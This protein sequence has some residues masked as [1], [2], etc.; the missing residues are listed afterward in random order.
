MNL[1]P[2][3][4]VLQCLRTLAGPPDPTHLSD[5]HLLLRY[6]RHRDELSFAALVRR[7]APMV[8]GVCCRILTCPQDAEDV[9][10]ATFLVLA[11]K[12]PSLRWRDSVASW[13]FE[14]AH[15]LALK[16]RTEIARRQRH[17]RQAAKMMRMENT[18]DGSLQE[19]S[20][21]LDEELRNLP[22]RY[23]LP[24]LLCY[25]EGRTR[26]Q[27][28]RY[29]GW[30]LRTLHR[31]LER[32][33]ALLRARLTARDLTLSSVLVSAELAQQTVSAHLSATLLRDTVHASLAFSLPASAVRLPAVVLAEQGLRSMA[34]AKGTMMLTLLLAVGVIATGVGVL[35]QRQVEAMRADENIT[36]RT[37]EPL[38]SQPGKSATETSDEPRADASA[39]PAGA[40]ARL[41]TSWLRGGRWW[42]FL[43]DGKR[44]VQQRSDDEALI[45]SAVPS[46]KPLALIRGSDVPGRKEVIG[47]TMAF[48]CDVKYLAAVC[49]EGRCGIWETATG[50]LVRWLE[51]GPFYSIVTCDFSPDGKLLAVGAGTPQGKI[52]GI[53]VGVYEVA[54]GKQLFTT[55]GT[56]SVFAPDGRSL[57]TWDGYGHGALKTARRVEVP[58]GKELTSFAYREHFPDFAPRSDGVWFFEIQ[59]NNSIRVWDV[60]SAKLKHTFPG[61]GGGDARLVYVRHIAGRRE[62]I[63]VSTQPAEVTCWDLRIGKQLWQHR[64]AAPAYYPSLSADGNTLVTGESTGAVRVWDVATGNER[65]SFRPGVIGHTTYEVQVSLDGKR[66]ATH[67]GGSFSSAVAF[68]DAT[69]G[70][71]LSDLPGHSAGITTVAYA[72]NG[73]R[74]FT[75][76]KDRTLRTWDAGSGRELSRI[77]TEPATSLAVSPDSKTLYAGG[78]ESGSVRVLDAQTGR[79]VRQLPVFRKTTIGL[80]LTADG[81]R[82]IAGGADDKASANL[83]V[84]IC[85][86]GTGAKQQ[87]LDRF[88]FSLEQLAI[89][90]DG[91]T[92]ATSHAGQRVLLWDAQGKKVAEQVGHGQRKPAWVKKQAT[93]QIGSLAL[94]ANGRWLAYSDQ[95]KGIVLVDARS[96]RE[97]ARAKVDVYYQAPSAREEV[98]DVLAFAPDGKT[99]AFSG[100]ESTVEIF[101]IEAR[102]QKVRQRLPGDSCPV[103]HLVFSPDGSQ[104]LSAGPDGSALLWDLFQP[105][106][107]QPVKAEQVAA[108]WEILADQDAEKAYRTMKEMA[109]HPAEA[110]KLLRTKL[111]PIRAVKDARLDALLAQLD[112]DEF[113]ER[114]AA[115]RELIALGDAVEPRLQS[116][117]RGAPSLELKRR[118]EDVLRRIDESRLRSERAIEVL[119][120]I[121]EIASRKHL[122]EL[123][124]GLTGAAR[125]NDAA[126][127]LARLSRIRKERARP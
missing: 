15:R 30:S 115:S 27:A 11:R 82:L 101:L 85:D 84:R 120:M 52:E 94:S 47:S 6:A 34:F 51:S 88:D 44:L 9:F 103:Q 83:S 16:S 76:G 35:T 19:L 69:T 127:T 12:A 74:I 64:L 100:V 118:T 38:H 56:N 105:P 14:V 126:E 58:S 39:L 67:S 10:Q 36:I 71:L 96:G 45:I 55:P 75:M 121:G 21:V 13:L 113:K 90:P 17:E 89:T 107:A 7:H 98:R 33:L 59:D 81:K 50:R 70:K 31:R 61:Q 60:A 63:S 20:T 2:L 104:L 65:T 87:E 97:V 29:M 3:Y 57:V 48:T 53:T 42:F 23:R 111:P 79:L 95:E 62:L 77:S 41:G 109:A 114:E 99:I 112:A 5:R 25:L 66:I 43:P 32:G 40:R 106:P 54:S 72:P 78:A 124:D 110:V 73:T 123:A 37:P 26:D 102:T 4:S 24:L 122:R 80:L 93:Y 86:A 18:R 28:A 119:A 46:G 91:R 8:M 92:I 22:E 49:W 1:H 108:W 117:L 125:T 68:W 116:V